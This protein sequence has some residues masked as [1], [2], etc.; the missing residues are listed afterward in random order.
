MI[1]IY[2]IHPLDNDEKDKQRNQ[3]MDRLS[4]F[5][6]NDDDFLFSTETNLHL[7]KELIQTHKVFLFYTESISMMG[8]SYKDLMDLITLLLKNQCCFRSESDNVSIGGDDRDRVHS[9][10]SEWFDES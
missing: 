5:F 3:L 1:L 6:I 2:A 7:L 4:P 9:M 8:L 10:L